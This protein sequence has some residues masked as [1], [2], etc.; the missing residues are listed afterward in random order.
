MSVAFEF[1]NIFTT[2]EFYIMEKLRSKC[3]RLIE[4][5]NPTDIYT[6][7]RPI[8]LALSFKGLFPFKIVENADDRTLRIS[9]F[10]YALAAFHISAFMI[11]FIISIWRHNSFVI[12]FFPTEISRFGGQLQFLTSIVVMV[13]IYGSCTYSA[14]K[15]R[16]V[17]DN[18]LKIDEKLKLLGLGIDHNVGFK[19]NVYFVIGFLAVNFTFTFLSFVLIAT[20]EDDDNMPGFAV[21]TSYFVPPFVVSLV[22]IYFLSIVYQIRQRFVHANQVS[23]MMLCFWYCVDTRNL[24]L[25]TKF[26]CTCVKIVFQHLF[27]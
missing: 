18:I 17:M 19:L 5:F 27:A 26:S 25:L 15:I 23:K 20:A 24:K 22:V 2:R 21:W 12:F 16:I 11:S 14:K 8:S 4:W 7:Q 13:S 10:G 6:S 3:N 1:S 9:K